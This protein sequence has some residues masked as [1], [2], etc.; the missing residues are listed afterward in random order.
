MII[1]SH[2]GYWKSPAEKNTAAAFIRSFS[3][4]F[5]TETD[6]RDFNGKLVISHDIPSAQSIT[7][8]T[9]LNIY[10]SECDGTLPLA[11]NIKSCGLSELLKKTFDAHHIKNYFVFDLSVP[12]M[13][14]Y[15]KQGI[16]TYTRQSEFEP[17]PVFLDQSSGVWLDAFQSVWYTGEVLQR[18]LNNGKQICLVS[19]ELHGRPMTEIYPALQDKS[20]QH[21]PR[22][23]LCTDFP[24]AAKE[25]FHA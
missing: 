18:Y 14:A 10:T 1:L 7:L 22:L 21:D 8:E 11:I 24:E 19:P 16:A 20:L 3:M 5:G 9:F 2:R 12:D 4:G 17:A 6:V 23:M 15:F 25:Q 13:F